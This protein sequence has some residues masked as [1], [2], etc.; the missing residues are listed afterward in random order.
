MKLLSIP[1]GI[2]C[3]SLLAMASQPATTPPQ[4]PDIITRDQ[5][6]SKP[7]PLPQDARHTPRV[8]TVHH[9]GVLWRPTDEPYARIRNL[10]SWGQR[11][12][13]WPDLPYHYLISPDGRIFEGRDVNYRP[14]SNTNYEL[15]GTLNVHLWGNFDEQRVS[16]E[17]LRALVALSAHLCHTLGLNPAEI[18]GHADAAPGQTSCPGKDLQRYITQGLLQ[19]WTADLLAGR[20]PDI[21]PLP[22]L[23][24]GP[25]APIPT[26]RP[27]ET[28]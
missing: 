5:W 9:A 18:R 23:D 15:S 14:E 10:Q 12:K 1:L 2:A 27:A 24:D 3:L 25:T 19:R 22:P 11:D 26:T 13:N 17:Q 16:V 4:P 6:G 28:P 20:S 8:L 7:Q 21:T